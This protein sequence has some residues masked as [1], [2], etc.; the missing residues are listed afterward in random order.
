MTHRGPF[1]PLPFCDSVILGSRHRDRALGRGYGRAACPEPLT[2]L[3]PRVSKVCH[4]RE[5]SVSQ[6][7]CFL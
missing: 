4:R 3:L 6:H 5:T 1:Q 7:F 2:W